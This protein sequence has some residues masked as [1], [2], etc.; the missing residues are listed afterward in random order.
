[1]ANK[2]TQGWAAVGL[3]LIVLGGAFY[4]L[5]LVF[6]LGLAV[7]DA[8]RESG[9]GVYLFLIVPG[10]AGLGLLILLAKVIVDRLGNAEDDYY[11]KNVDQ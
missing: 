11:A 8:A 6:G 10:F 1:M 2:R 9:A 3:S 4:A 5:A 7:Q